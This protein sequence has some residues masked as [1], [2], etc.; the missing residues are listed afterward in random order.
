MRC[1]LLGEK[2]GHSYSPQIHALLSDYSYD[3][4]EKEPQQLEDFL[5]NGQYHGL[6]VTIPY[7]KVVIPYCNCLSSE[8]QKL[9]AVNTITKAADGTLTGHNTDYFGFQYMLRKSQLDVTG[10]KVLILG[11]GGAAVTVFS[12][13]QEA[14]ATPV[15]ISRRG[16]NNYQNLQLHKDASVIVN[17]TPVGMYP[18][19]GKSPVNINDF[20]L[21]EGALDL[22]YNPARTQLL[23]DAE[24]KG[25]VAV[26]GLWMLVAQAKKSAELFTGK[27]LP[28]GM[29][30][31]IYSQLCKKMQN[32]IL[33]GMPGCGKS[34][35]GKLLAAQLGQEFVDVDMYIEQLAQKTIPTIFQEGGEAA[36]RALESQALRELGKRSGLVIA[37]GGG[38]VTQAQNYPLLHQNGNIIWIKRDL[39]LLPTNGRPLS[40]KTSLQ[41]M[42]QQR[43]NLYAVFADHTVVNETTLEEAT[44]VIAALENT[45]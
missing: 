3:L 2:L 23:L 38:C 39:N 25:L 6:N 16:E 36:F 27:A 9:G 13:L 1:G 19:T 7:K 21:L 44:A 33:I 11:S 30:D 17:A 14:G 4:F 40:Q 5:C 20:P 45:I 34:T 42:Y 43:Q 41:S 37:T 15:I 31:T 32:T 24:H 29:I 28:D 18:N 35:V 12:V 26:N 10:K 22:I 8:A